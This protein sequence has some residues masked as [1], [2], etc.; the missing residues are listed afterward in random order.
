MA[1]HVEDFIRDD[2]GGSPESHIQALS[3]KLES[4]GDSSL[5]NALELVL[6]HLNQ[7]PSYDHREVLILYSALSS[8]DPGD[9]NILETI[10]KWKKSRLR[11]SVIGLSAEMFICKHL[12]QD[13]VDELHLKDLL[14]EDAPPP[15]A[16]AEFAVSNLIEMGSHKELLRVQWQY[17]AK[18]GAGYTCPRC[19]ARVCELP[20][21]CAFCVLTLV[22]SSHPARSYHYLFSIASFDEAPTLSSSNQP[23]RKLGKSCFGCQQ[24]LLGAGNKP[25]PCVTCRKCK[26]YSCLD[27]DKY[28]HESLHN[29]RGCVSIH[30]PKSVSMM[31][32]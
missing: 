8:C 3:G 25:G 6:E 15:P 14:L 19:E 11:C 18:I 32:E 22:S 9:L 28:I 24:S 20:T 7:I 29:C 17:E 5:Q 27:C 21:E 30:R 1:K 23:R 12:C 4:S 13:T 10:Q 16:I 26:H 31:E 2:L